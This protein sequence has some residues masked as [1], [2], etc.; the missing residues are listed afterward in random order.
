M[1]FKFRSA[2]KGN[3]FKPTHAMVR[4]AY[5]RAKLGDKASN[6]EVSRQMGLNQ[7]RYSKWVSDHPGF[8]EWLEDAVSKNRTPVLDLLECV[9]IDRLSEDY[10]Y[11]ETIAK[12]YG[13][14]SDK[15]M[16]IKAQAEILVPAMTKEDAEKL[17]EK[18]RAQ[19]SN[20]Q[21]NS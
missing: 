14:I 4:Y 5:Y 10:R 18:I 1:S 12:K 13:Y 21:E 19:Q 20:V 9:A 6:S 8:E 7:G 3:N 17:L 2:P 15:P 11:W 16:E